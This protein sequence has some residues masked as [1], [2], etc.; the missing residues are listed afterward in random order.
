MVNALRG[1]F[2]KGVGDTLHLHPTTSGL[3]SLLWIGG[4]LVVFVP[5]CVM[6][7]RRISG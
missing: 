1:W 6:R 7:F 4:V 3:Q 5:L 2:D